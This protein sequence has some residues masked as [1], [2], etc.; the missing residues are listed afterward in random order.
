VRFLVGLGVKPSEFFAAIENQFPV[1]VVKP[2]WARGANTLPT[3]VPPSSAD[4][5]AEVQRTL[6]L[7]AGH[8]AQ[9][10]HELF[11]AHDIGQKRRQ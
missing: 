5:A 8:L 9:R 4:D 10:I 7:E 6:L 2:A 3:E 1:P 11:A